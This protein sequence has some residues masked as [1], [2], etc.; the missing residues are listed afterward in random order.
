MSNQDLE[1][2]LLGCSRDYDIAGETPSTPTTAGEDTRQQEARDAPAEGAS[3]GAEAAPA[4]SQVAPDAEDDSAELATLLSLLLPSRGA[5]KRCDSAGS[6]AGSA[7][8]PPI[9]P[10][11]EAGAPPTSV[12][13]PSG[14]PDVEAT[15]AEQRARLRGF[16]EQCCGAGEG[17]KVWD[18]SVPDAGCLSEAQPGMHSAAFAPGS[19]AEALFRRMHS[20]TAAEELLQGLLCPLIRV[21]MHLQACMVLQSHCHAPHKKG[22]AVKDIAHDPVIAA[23]GFT[24]ERAAIAEWMQHSELSPVT[25]KPMRSMRLCRNALFRSFV[26]SLVKASGAVTVAS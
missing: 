14:S 2:W 19:M 11:A 26:S 1:R 15:P 6:N 10:P 16:V 24:Y 22:C 3:S 9:T 12:L 25:M 4:S 5:D 23:D 18:G 17:A 13:Q 7:A 8:D 21:C 20:S